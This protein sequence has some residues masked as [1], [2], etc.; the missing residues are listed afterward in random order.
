[1]AAI[2][3]AICFVGFFVLGI[4]AAIAI[5]QFN[6]YRMRSYQASVKAALHDV[7]T[8]EN[9]YFAQN[10]AYTDSLEELGYIPRPNVTIQIIETTDDCF[11]AQGEMTTLQTRYII[12]CDCEITEEEITD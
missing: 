9:D 1:M 4:I 12:D 5:P 10:N 7:C 3:V 2:G 8:A 11:Y 6:A